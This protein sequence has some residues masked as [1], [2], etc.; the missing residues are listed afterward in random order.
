MGCPKRNLAL[1]GL[2]LSLATTLQAGILG[3]ALFSLPSK[4][5]YLEYDNLASLRR[6]PNYSSL[7]QEFS[8][9]SLD[10]ARTVLVQLGIDES[11]VQEIVVAFSSNLFEGLVAGTFSVASA[12]KNPKRNRYAA[13]LLD[14]QVFC[15]GRETCVVFLEDSV[16]AFGSVAQLKNMLLTRQGALAGL[17]SN[18]SAVRLL[19]GTD[20]RAP[21]RGILFGEQLHA[22]VAGMFQDWSSLKG[23]GSRL[24]DTISGLGYSVTFDGKAHVNATIECTSRTTAALLSQTFN[25]LAALQS[26]TAPLVSAAANLPFQNVQV[27]SSGNV[28]YFRADTQ[29]PK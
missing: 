4:T 15:T 3:D 19:N 10:E 28:M 6:L 12:S 9:K 11:E 22:A 20:Q 27:S 14:T 29:L 24:A 21:V 16:V 17:N 23:E 13:K 1:V 25:G 7:R 8:G 26:F 5:E 18:S 2:A